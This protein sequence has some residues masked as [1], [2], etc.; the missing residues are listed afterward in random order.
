MITDGLG[1]FDWHGASPEEPMTI[2]YESAVDIRCGSALH[3]VDIMNYRHP[4]VEEYDMTLVSSQLVAAQL[5]FGVCDKC[6]ST[7]GISSLPR[8][9][10]STS[11]SHNVKIVSGIYT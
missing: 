2:L 5:K 9:R 6:V 4:R 3:H 1:R 10:A 8:R 7:D 11:Y